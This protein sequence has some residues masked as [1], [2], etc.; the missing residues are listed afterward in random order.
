MSNPVD[1]VSAAR[2]VPASP[3]VPVVE[4]PKPVSAPQQ[5]V[6]NYVAPT[7]IRRVNPSLTQEARA[8]LRRTTRK[9]TVTVRLDI[10]ETGTVRNAQAIGLTGE[11]ANGGV[12]VKL[13]AMAAARQW[14]F[15]P[16]TI[17]GKSVS[18][19]MTVIFEY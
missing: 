18:S 1:Q 8:E 19:Q 2:D 15:R 6:S 16:A 13:V 14:K 3:S 10:D 5:Q 4:T 12:Y 7:A 17:N 9:V 11:P